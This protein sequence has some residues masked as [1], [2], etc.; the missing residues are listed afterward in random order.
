[1]REKRPG[2]LYM[3]SMRFFASSVEYDTPVFEYI[4]TV[5]SWRWRFAS[6]RGSI[7]ASR[8]GRRTVARISL[9]RKRE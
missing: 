4:I 3:V 5:F 8:F 6:K 7:M 9:S 1:M 2:D